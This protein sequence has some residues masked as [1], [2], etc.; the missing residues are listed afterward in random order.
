[1]KY[2]ATIDLYFL[3]LFERDV[4]P[5][6]G[7]SGPKK[8][9]PRTYACSESQRFSLSGFPE[10]LE[11]GFWA[12][13]ASSLECSVYNLISDTNLPFV[14]RNGCIISMFDL[15]RNFFPKETLPLNLTYFNVL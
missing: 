2:A 9:N 7:Q 5:K 1:V 13:Q 14:V 3:D 6:S 15:F 12:I 10:H 11:E 4:Q 8:W